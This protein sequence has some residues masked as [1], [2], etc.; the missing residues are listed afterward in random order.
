MRGEVLPPPL[1]RSRVHV[2]LQDAGSG[3]VEEEVLKNIQ[4]GQDLV[5]KRSRLTFFSKLFFCFF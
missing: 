5:F 3:K 4:I 2:R 1:A